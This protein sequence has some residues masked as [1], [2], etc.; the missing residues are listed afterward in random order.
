MIQ[1]F[2]PQTSI[3]VTILFYYIHVVVTFG[4]P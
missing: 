2:A 1:K 3:E 4:V